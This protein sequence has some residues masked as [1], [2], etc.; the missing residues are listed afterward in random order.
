MLV[1]SRKRGQT[2]HFDGPCTIEVLKIS[3]N[4]IRFGIEAA[5]ETKVLRGELV[6]REPQDGQAAEEGGAAA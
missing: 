5:P 6:D 1:L 3:G 4:T 2:L